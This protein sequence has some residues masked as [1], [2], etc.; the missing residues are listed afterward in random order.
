MGGWLPK[1]GIPWQ[2]YPQQGTPLARSDGGMGTQGGVP[3]GRGTPLARSD[4][5]YLRWGTP[6]RG[7]PLARSDGGYPR[8]GTPAGGTRAGPGWDTPLA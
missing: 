7:Y 1:V 5:E 8:W 4:G 3:P 6:S 2:G